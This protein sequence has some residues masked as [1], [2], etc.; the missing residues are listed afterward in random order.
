[1]PPRS[2]A[3]GVG[4]SPSRSSRRTI[5]PICKILLIGRGNKLAMTMSI[6]PQCHAMTLSP[7]LP[8]IG[9][10]RP[11]SVKGG[12]RPS[13]QNRASDA[14]RPWRV[15]VDAEQSKSGDEPEAAKVMARAMSARRDL[16]VP[17][18]DW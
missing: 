18:P 3:A 17:L 16:P 13:R 1:V 10:F 6:T 11:G 7:Q 15:P 5:F 9:D 4:I 2:W 8:R 14:K 12:R